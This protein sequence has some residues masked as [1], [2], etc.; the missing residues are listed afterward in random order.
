MLAVPW[1]VFHHCMDIWASISSIFLSVLARSSGVDG[2]LLWKKDG[3]AD[4]SCPTMASRLR[5]LRSMSNSRLRTKSLRRLRSIISLS[6]CLLK[7]SSRSGSFLSSSDQ[8]VAGLRTNFTIL[9]SKPGVVSGFGISRVVKYLRATG[10]Y[11][12]PNIFCLSSRRC[13]A[14]SDRLAVGRAISRP[15]PMGSPVSSQ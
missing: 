14:S 10:G 6:N 3:P 11:Q 2:M 9:E 1:L 5:I 8:L 13:C 7:A 15:T 4:R 12:S